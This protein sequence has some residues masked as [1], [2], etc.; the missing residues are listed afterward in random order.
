M[1][2]DDDAWLD[3]LVVLGEAA[4]EVREHAHLYGKTAVGAAALTPPMYPSSKVLT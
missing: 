4:W 3:Q 2:S 1:S